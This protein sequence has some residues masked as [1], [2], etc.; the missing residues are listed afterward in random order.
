MH[1]SAMALEVIIER[2]YESLR[3]AS[4]VRARHFITRGMAA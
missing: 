2:W 1:V 3:F 4:F